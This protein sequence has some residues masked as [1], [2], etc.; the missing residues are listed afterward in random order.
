MSAG[1]GPRSRTRAW[2]AGSPTTRTR[3]SF[4]DWVIEAD[5]NM[6]MPAEFGFAPGDVGRRRHRRALELVPG[7]CLEPRVPRWARWNSRRAAITSACRETP[8]G[9]RDQFSPTGVERKRR[10]ARMAAATPQIARIARSRAANAL[11]LT[12][13]LNAVSIAT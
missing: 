12:C 7:R 11:P 4:G 9:A 1:G 10:V 2:S 13:G 8:L 6:N 3:R 5:G